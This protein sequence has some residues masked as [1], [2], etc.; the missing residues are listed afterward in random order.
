MPWYLNLQQYINIEKTPL[1]GCFSIFEVGFIAVAFF[2]VASWLIP[3][4]LLPWVSWHSEVMAFF[5]SLLL[6]WVALIR[7]LRF[8]STRVIKL[9]LFALPFIFLA[10][11]A[12]IQWVFGIITFAGDAMLLLLY[13]GLC[14]VCLTL[15][16]E[17]SSQ[18]PSLAIDSGAISQGSRALTFLAFSLTFGA[19]ISAILAFAQ[20]FELYEMSGWINVMPQL[21]RPGGNLGQPNQLAT[22]LL[23]GIASLLFLYELGKVNALTSILVFLVMGV[24]LALTESRTGVLSFL[25]L[26]CW[27]F[28][29]KK[30]V[31]FRVSAWIVVSAIVG[32][33]MFFWLWPM[34]FAFL[35]QSFGEPG[36]NSKIGLRLIV[37]PQLLDAVLQRPWFGWGLGEVAK[38]HNSVAHAYQISEPFSYSHNVLIDL[39]LGAGLPIALLFTCIFGSWLWLR[40]KSA[41]HLGSWYCLAVA[42]PFFV[43]SMLEFPFA[44]AYFLVPVMFA[45]GILEGRLEYN[46]PINIG[47][48]SAAALLFCLS[49]LAM[50]SLVEYVAIEEDFRIARFEVLRVGK[51]QDN[52]R[53]PHV[54]LLTQLSALLDGTRISPQPNMSADDLEVVKKIAL[55]YPWTATQN[56]YALSMA[57]NGNPVEAVRQLRVMRAMHG[58]QTYAVI[59]ASW[60]NLALEKYPQLREFTVP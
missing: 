56:R 7:C 54:V 28:G 2:L 45:L 52:Y 25:I 1:W 44:Y 38:A 34:I 57:L 24:A 58:E 32:F 15:G 35:A 9:P 36:I 31:G 60:R 14:V 43:H 17:L 10:L 19:F 46:S 3:L 26:S 20:V 55:R 41:N 8:G 50:W 22:L 33:I 29:K 5:A 27:W 40:I 39:A 37:W 53:R 51:T 6:G 11:L 49:T 12:I 21:R 42:L 23:I 4:H 18:K 48:P 13:M 30:C 59:R 47:F 16:S